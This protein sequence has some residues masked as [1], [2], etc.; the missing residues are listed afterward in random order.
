MRRKSWPFRLRVIDEVEGPP[1]EHQIEQFWHTGERLERLDES[2]FRIGS[3]A[4]LRLG[5]GSQIATESGWRSRA[6][7]RQEASGVVIA[8][9]QARLPMRM[10]VTLFFG[11][12]AERVAVE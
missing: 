3:R 4:V 5:E 6:Y 11:D 2:S 7:G 12:E 10:V 8:R 1:G 9:R